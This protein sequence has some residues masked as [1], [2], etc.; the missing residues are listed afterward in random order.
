MLRNTLGVCLTSILLYSFVIV[1]IEATVTGI[2]RVFPKPKRATPPF[3]PSD[4]RRP[5]DTL[6]VRSSDRHDSKTSLCQ[7]IQTH[8]APRKEHYHSTIGPWLQA[9]LDEWHRNNTNYRT[10]HGFGFFDYLTDRYA[11]LVTASTKRCN[12]EH[13]CTVSVDPRST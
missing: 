5:M 13:K 3:T 6:V 1:P 7:Y 8:P 11:P 9:R 2:D 10:A 12:L 4:S